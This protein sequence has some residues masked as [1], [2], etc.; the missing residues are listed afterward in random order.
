MKRF[1]AA[2]VAAKMSYAG[3]FQFRGMP[4]SSIRVVFLRLFDDWRQGSVATSMMRSDVSSSNARA[5][6][7][8]TVVGSPNRAFDAA[9]AR[10]WL[11]ARAG[12][13]AKATARFAEA[14]LLESARVP[15]AVGLPGAA[16]VLVALLS[17]CAL[18]P[19]YVRPERDR[20]GRFRRK[21][22]E[23]HGLQGKKG[24]EAHGAIGSR[25]SRRL[26]DDLSR[27]GA[28]PA[29]RP[30]RNLESDRGG[31]RSRLPTGVGDDPRGAG[32]AVSDRHQQLFRR[33]NPSGE[34][35]LHGY[36]FFLQRFDCQ[37]LLVEQF[38]VEQCV[39]HE[40]ARLQLELHGGA[41][42]CLGGRRVGPHSRARLKPTPRR[43][44]SARPTSPMRS[45]WRR[46]NSSPPISICAPRTSLRA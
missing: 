24:L 46:R 19:D 41:E 6:R 13:R 43:R 12:K 38:V 33:G 25:R 34:G 22:R 37:R 23:G 2:A 7:F 31:R 21:G 44:K 1:V 35:K 40:R 15:R 27:T 36:W 32:R 8:R 17:G 20:V 9:R 11:G 10:R 3:L 42:R 39:L 5:A 14:G 16:G 29:G 18:G 26:V 4:L 30:S 28:G 45:C